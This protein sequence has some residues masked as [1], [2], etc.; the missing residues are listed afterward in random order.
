MRDIPWKGK[1]NCNEYFNWPCSNWSPKDSLQPPSSFSSFFLQ[2][3]LL[4]ADNMI[5]GLLLFICSVTVPPRVQAHH[6]GRWTLPVC[7][8]WQ[9]E[10]REGKGGCQISCNLQLLYLGLTPLMAL[11]SCLYHET[12]GG[13]KM[14]IKHRLGFVLKVTVSISCSNRC[15]QMKAKS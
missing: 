9:R 7:A 4:L 6:R 13:R 8:A 10:K 11:I 12:V 5:I 1:K 2:N 3:M 15:V 14:D